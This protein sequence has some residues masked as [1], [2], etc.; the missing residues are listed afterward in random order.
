MGEFLSNKDRRAA[1]GFL[2]ALLKWG[3]IIPTVVVALVTVMAGILAVSIGI[4][5]ADF[6]L[7]LISEVAYAWSLMVTYAIWAIWFLAAVFFVTIGSPDGSKNLATLWYPR[8]PVCAMP[9]AVAAAFN[10]LRASANLVLAK[11]SFVAGLSPLRL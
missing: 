8:K 3:L 9:A 10:G 6:A 2:R 1:V 5:L 4:S 11:P 7:P